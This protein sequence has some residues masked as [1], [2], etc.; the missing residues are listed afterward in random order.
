MENN[1]IFFLSAEVA[2]ICD[3]GERL[4]PGNQFPLDCI[5]RVFF[6]EFPNI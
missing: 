6:L 5:V 2:H 4:G 1:E 3:R